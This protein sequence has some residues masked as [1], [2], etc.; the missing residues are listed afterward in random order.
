[1]GR[2]RRVPGRTVG[3]RRV[4]SALLVI[5]AP[6]NRDERRVSPDAR[7]VEKPQTSHHSFRQTR[8]AEPSRDFLQIPPQKTTADAVLK[9]EVF[10]ERY[11]M[12]ALVGVL[13]TAGEH[14]FADR[15][16]SSTSPSDN[17]FAVPGGLKLPDDERIPMLIDNFLQNVHTK[18][19]ILD[20]E[21]L[22]KQGRK[23]AEQGL[24]WDAW[25]CLVLLACALGSVAKPFDT[26]APLPP[27]I[28]A[29]GLDL[30]TAS[31]PS[32]VMFARELHQV[33][34]M[35]T[36]RPLLSWQYFY[37]ASIIYHL[38]LKTMHGVFGVSSE[39]FQIPVQRLSAMGQKQ[40]RLEQCLYWS[41]FKSECEFRIELPLPQSEIA[42][43]DFP[44]MFPSPPSP[45]VAEPTNRQVSSRCP[46]HAVVPGNDP[47]LD[48]LTRFDTNSSLNEEDS[49]LRQHAKRLCNE[50]ESWYYYLTEIALRRIGNRIINTFFRQSHGS[51][52]N[53]KPLL[54]IAMEF[55]DQVSSWS[56]HLPPAIQH[57]E[58]T[59]TI[60]A[61]TFHSPTEE[62]HSF[63]SRE[64][65]WA[66]DNRLLEMRSWL[67]QPFLYYLIHSGSSLAPVVCNNSVGQQ[68]GTSTIDSLLNHYAPPLHRS[69]R[70]SNSSTRTQP[71]APPPPLDAEET[72]ILRHMIKSGIDCNLKVLDVRTLRHRH[73]GLWYDLRSIMCA[74]LVLLAVV[75]SGHQAWIPGSVQTLWGGSGVF[76]MSAGDGDGG[77]ARQE[78]GGRIGRVLAQFD[79]WAAESPDLVRHREVLE[80]VVRDV[81]ERHEANRG[82]LEE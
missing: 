22:V 12:N 51:W 47:M 46:S 9:W 71:G 45:S 64:L 31:P 59:S 36:L 25:S 7:L 81:R 65:S 32:A 3:K 4:L 48:H 78:I 33:Y 52:L 18:N 54:R 19:P 2:L 63:V 43:C 67:Y 66:T 16:R 50:E 79:F 37:Q 49:E 56:T 20:V 11:P 14:D 42:G 40:R 76:A 34:L 58:T 55:D 75:K 21:S 23:C 70:N 35:Y 61:P 30:A 27:I 41:C 60:R 15:R 77:G 38:Y 17:A 24:G 62:P 1:M 80:D 8:V 44:D 29:E 53:I 6:S 72:A 73:H 82:G 13:F 26:A 69:H 28:R 68:N 10:E 74:S 57:Y 39:P 5:S